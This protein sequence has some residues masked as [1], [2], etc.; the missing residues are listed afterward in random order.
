MQEALVLLQDVDDPEGLAYALTGVGAAIALSGDPVRCMQYLEAAIPIAETITNRVLLAIILYYH[1]RAA[2][3]RGDFAQAR[4]SFER[5]TAIGRAAGNRP[6]IAHPLSME[7]RLAIAEGRIEAAASALGESLEIH[8]ENG[9][10]W[11]VVHTLEGLAAVA[12]ARKNFR[13]AALLLGVSE[14]MREQ[15]QV[16]HS[17]TEQAA[18]DVLR[19][20]VRS[21]LGAAAAE[22]WREGGSLDQG[23]AARVGLA[24]AAAAI[25][26]G[27][28]ST[29]S[30][31]AVQRPQPPAVDL[32]VRALGSLQ[33]LQQGTPIPASAWGSARPRELLVM[34]MMNPEGCTKEQVGLAFWPEAS[35]AQVRN[36][37]HVTLHRLRRALGHPEWIET[38]AERYRLAASLHWEIDAATALKRRDHAALARAVAQYRGDF[39]D[40]EG[41]GD[42]HFP[43]RDRLQRLYVDALSALANAQAAAGQHEEAAA[44][45]RLLLARDPLHEEAW[46]RLMTSHAKQ[47]ERNQA[48][49]LYQ[50]LTELLA[51]ELDAE[52]DP[53]TAD[54]AEA[55]GRGTLG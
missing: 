21:G 12:A 33:V 7:G 39:L 4:Q 40:G 5:A 29:A 11:G 18:Y 24:V 10:W 42:W 3:D 37:F 28:M 45:S 47:G 15:M 43:I 13:D 46:R 44:T 19:A 6:T 52:P 48:L 2:Q 50:Q 27:G 14:A 41:A 26:K 34:L 51:R 38:A 31:P 22:L 32:M 9:D 53:E 17:P 35:T 54:L 30:T 23:G 8:H 25:A 49:K 1:G 16:K 36:S 20:T 55:I